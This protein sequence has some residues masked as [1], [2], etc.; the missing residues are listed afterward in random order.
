M[1]RRLFWLRDT[2]HNV[3]TPSDFPGLIDIGTFGGFPT[4]V[5]GET[6][7][8]TN[9]WYSLRFEDADINAA[10]TS[11]WGIGV[12]IDKT[13]GNNP[14]VDLFNP[15]DFDDYL[16]WREVQFQ[17]VTAGGVS[18]AVGPDNPMTEIDTSTQRFAEFG[19]ALLQ[20]VWQGTA[21]ISF[22]FRASYSLLVRAAANPTVAE[23]VR[24]RRT[25]DEE[26]AR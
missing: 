4:L 25:P 22:D 10:L 3:L 2:I 24:T 1:A 23:A 14:P 21:D 9:I 17:P 26:S 20:I 6:L 7:T 13:N 5:K 11:T 15:T 18:Y 8:R 16:H 12:R 19:P